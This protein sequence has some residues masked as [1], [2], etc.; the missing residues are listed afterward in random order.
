MAGEARPR[1]ARRQLPPARLAGEPPA[2]LGCPDPL[3]LLR[4]GRDG[5]GP[6]GPAPGRAP[7]HRRLR[8]EGQEPARG[9]RGLGQHHLSE[10]RRTRPPRDGHDGHVRRLLVVLPPLPRLQERRGPMEPRGR[11]LL[12]ARG[13]IHRRRRARDS[14]P[15]VRALLRQG[16]RGH[17]PAR[18][19][20]AVHQP[21]RAGN[22]HARR[23]EDV[24]VARQHGQ[25][26]GVR[27]ALRRRHHPHL[28]LLHGPADQGRR[29][30]R[31]GRRGRLPLPRPGLA[32]G[33][34]GRGA[35][36]SP[37]GRPME[38]AAPRA[39]PASCSP[40]RTGRSTRSPAT[41][42]RGSSSTRPSPR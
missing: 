24:E 7:R 29:L 14:A 9:R 38:P 27:R 17:G 18:R 4:Y 42:S 33:A 25:P 30:V 21:V 6:R 40:R 23:G 19:A 3:R 36:R 32:A 41:S 10:V 1:Q 20:G 12:D 26:G 39:R 13:P 8:A 28:H 35:R 37:A 5:P 22:D 34:G 31:R 16:A 15:D 2:L 11:G